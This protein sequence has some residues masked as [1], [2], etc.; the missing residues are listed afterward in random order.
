MAR[1]KENSQLTTKAV[2]LLQ[3]ANM[4]QLYGNNDIEY[5]IYVRKSTED[6]SGERQAQS[7][8]DQIE[9][10]V[11]YAKENNLPIKKKPLKFEFE[12]QEEL[13]MED[14]DK[15]PKNRRIYQETRHLYIIK[16]RMSGS[17]LGR[18]KWNKLIEKIRRWEIKGLISYSPDRQARNMVDGWNIIDCVDNGLVDLKYTNFTF[19]PNSAGKM[20]LG[21]YFVFSKQ[22][23]DKLSEDVDRWKKSSVEK[24]NT[25]WE[26]KY[27]YRRDENKHYVPD[28][29]NFR[30][31]KE[32]FRMKVEDKASDKVIADWLNANGFYKNKWNRKEKVNAQ[33]LSN[34][35]TDTIYY[36]VYANGKNIQDLREVD[37]LNF[38]P[39][40]SEEWHDILIERNQAKHK[41]QP[42]IKDA[43]RND[44]YA[45]SIPVWML[46]LKGTEYSLS[47]YITKKSH[48]LAMYELALKENPG[49]ELEDFIKPGWVRYEIKT[50]S[51]KDKKMSKTKNGA[52][53]SINQ[54]EVEK[55]IAS[56]V[57]KMKI[58]EDD[59]RS[60]V[61]FI[62]TNMKALIKKN[63]KEKSAIN[64]RLWT[65]VKNRKEY[66]KKHMWVNFKNDEEKDIYE[67]TIVDFDEKERVLRDRLES[68]FVTDRNVALELEAVNT[69]L[70]R[71]ADTYINSSNV[72]KK[73]FVKK[74]F[75]NIYVDN[76]KGLT[77]EVSPSLK[78]ILAL[79]WSKPGLARI[80]LATR[81]FGDHRSTSELQPY[82]F[83]F[84]Q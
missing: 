20:M 47:P 65:L 38:V 23:S 67:E 10:C 11:Q 57:S 80:E 40:I 56:V 68:M 81:G 35:W 77:L 61:N 14:K 27:W 50:N 24:W 15:D 29:E 33:W 12:T 4:E 55:K 76:K 73:K 49:L 39:L 69:V 22:Y 42:M 25:Q 26:Y 37:G 74:L 31:M 1:K 7:I 9:R 18:P 46:K 75:S 84:N 66:I 34:V 43:I 78:I 62:D 83:L 13:E 44:E 3:A 48:R 28:G 17:A 32:A 21:I 71:A 16:E 30:L 51:V 72:R 8:A 64:M 70:E 53:I 60:Y 58:S 82:I 41:K 5:V 36:W 63:Q 2:R 54:D 6:Q 45:F 19:E 79:K 52:T 59:Y